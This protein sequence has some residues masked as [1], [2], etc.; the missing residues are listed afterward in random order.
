VDH[1][2]TADDPTADDDFV[3]GN[4]PFAEDA[5]IQWIAIASFRPRREAA[6]ALVTVG[7]WNKPVQ[8]RVL[9]GGV[10]RS[11]D[12]KIP[13]YFINLILH[14][15]ERRD[16]DVRVEN[17]RRIRTSLQTMPGVRSE[18]IDCAGSFTGRLRGKSFLC[19]RWHFVKAPF[20]EVCRPNGSA[21]TPKR[22]NETFLSRQSGQRRLT[23]ASP[24]Y[25]VLPG[26][27]SRARSCLTDSTGYR[28]C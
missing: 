19:S 25:A 22:P 21:L 7:A 9:C 20:S 5:D 4:R 3:P 1:L 15:V 10:L 12:A 13:G 14:E 2:Q 27:S 18:V 16:L 8:R 23:A 17:L 26:R 28:L 6:H 24:C 11:I